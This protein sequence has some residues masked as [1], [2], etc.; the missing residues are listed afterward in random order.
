MLQTYVCLA[1]SLSGD[2]L[3]GIVLRYSQGSV[4]QTSTTV[5]KNLKTVQYSQIMLL[6]LLHDIELWYRQ[7]CNSIGN[8]FGN[9]END[10]IL[11]FPSMSILAASGI[12]RT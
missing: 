8:K 6:V 3:I 7:Y 2:I 1:Y 9:L 11:V 10:E 12:M 4:I 5:C